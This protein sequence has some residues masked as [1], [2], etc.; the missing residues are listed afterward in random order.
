MW[1]DLKGG[2]EMAINEPVWANPEK[3]G[4]K[5]CPKCHGYGSSLDE[6]NDRCSLCG[7]SGL[8]KASG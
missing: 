5:E 6:D 3:H 7:G 4:L 2:D 8:V 1:A